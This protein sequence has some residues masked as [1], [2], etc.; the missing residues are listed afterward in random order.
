MDQVYQRPTTSRFIPARR[1]SGSIPRPGRRPLAAGPAPGSSVTSS[2]PVGL[3][4]PGHQLGL[5]EPQLGGPGGVATRPPPAPRAAANADWAWPRPGAGRRCRPSRR[6]PSRWRPPRRSPSRRSRRS[7]LSRTGLGSGSRLGRERLPRHRPRLSRS[8]RVHRAVARSAA[9]GR[10][11]RRAAAA[12]AVVSR[13]WA[14]PS[15]STSARLRSGSSSENTSSSSSSG[16][17]PAAAVTTWWAARRSASASVRCSPCE[18]WVRAAIPS[19]RQ[20]HVVA[21]GTDQ[22]D[23]PAEL[24]G[25]GRGQ[26]GGQAAGRARRSGRSTVISAAAAGQATVAGHQLGPQLR[27]AGPRGPGSA[28]HRRRPAWRSTRRG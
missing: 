22:A 12:P 8:A 15:E 5:Q 16:G 18:A 24:V 26:R 4:D 27:R 23:P 11:R 17:V 7:T 10:A 14:D 6:R 25:S 19:M 21:V 9:P 2:D 1:I 13:V 3:A 28:P 20:L